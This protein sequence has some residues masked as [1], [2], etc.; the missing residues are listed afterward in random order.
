MR[1]VTSRLR[2]I[3]HALLIS[4]RTPHAGSDDAV[5]V[6][7]E[8]IK[9]STRTPHAGSDP[10]PRACRN[11]DYISTR[12]PH[13]G[14]D[15]LLDA[16]ASTLMRFQPALP[17]RGVTPVFGR[18]G[19]DSIISTRTPHAGS[20]EAHALFPGGGRISTRTPHAGSDAAP[21]RASCSRLS[22]STRTP[23]AGS[24]SAC[25]SDRRPLGYFNPHSPCGE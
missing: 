20:D 13:A 4:T 15:S 3:A 21:A 2:R 17:M 7:S 12:T 18:K 8:A 24:D 11:R 1:G 23:H 19:E 5:N 14:S 16:P 25:S 22:I 6:D 9:I 10:R